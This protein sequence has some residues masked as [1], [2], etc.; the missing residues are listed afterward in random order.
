MKDRHDYI[1]VIPARYESTRLPGKPLVMLCGVPM[2]VRTYMQCI[3]VVPREQV[4]VATDDYRIRDVCEK[5]NIQVVMTSTTC[6]TGTDRVEEVSR[7]VDAG[8]YI[9]VQGDEPVFN[10]HD[11]RRLI[12]V[13]SECP[14]EVINGYC[15]IESEEM[16][17]SGAVPKVV[18]RPD[19]RLLYMSRAAIPTNKSQGFDKAKRQVCAYA[20]P[21]A[22][23]AAFSSSQAKTPLEA[24]E[25]IEILRFLELGWD[26]RMISLSNQSIAVDNPEDIAKAEAAIIGMDCK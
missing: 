21:K 1:V 9:N 14:Q 6:M 3:S 20:F 12:Q 7:E 16:F 15:D 13:A 10:P 25:D 17:R 26:V 24:I 8:F 4:F 2:V 5:E 23:L 18:V 22:A 19:G 11:L